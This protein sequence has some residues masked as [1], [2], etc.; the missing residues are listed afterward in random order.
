MINVLSPIFI[1][2]AVMPFY[3]KMF[4]KSNILMGSEVKRVNANN[5]LTIWQWDISVTGLEKFNIR[6]AL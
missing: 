2:E 5:E 6:Y 1:T 4:T 3:V